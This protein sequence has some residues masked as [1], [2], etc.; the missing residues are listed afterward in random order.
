MKTVYTVKDIAR[1]LQT[2]E[3][4][5]QRGLAIIASLSDNEGLKSLLANESTYTRKKML[6]EMQRLLGLFNANT[7][8]KLSKEAAEFKAGA[9][10]DFIEL[11]KRHGALYEVFKDVKIGESTKQTERLTNEMEQLSKDNVR[12][13]ADADYCQAHGKPRVTQAKEIT[14]LKEFVKIYHAARTQKSRI[15]SKIKA[16]KGHAAKLE[17]LTTKQRQNQDLLKQ[18][19]DMLETYV[20]WA[21][22]ES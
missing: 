20:I 5:Y 10:K 8:K 9:R 21:P 16:A 2:S 19:E 15:A 11:A 4:S 18:L 6:T 13:H 7:G 3:R 22:E 1:W 12:K 14:S 17:A